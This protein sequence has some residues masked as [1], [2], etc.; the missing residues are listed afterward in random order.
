MFDEL[1]LEWRL[2]VSA[3]GGTIGLHAYTFA[4]DHGTCGVVL[5]V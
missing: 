4:A 1:Y 5:Q 2:G 3:V